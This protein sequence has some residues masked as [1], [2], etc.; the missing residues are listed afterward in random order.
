MHRFKLHRKRTSSGM[1]EAFPLD[2]GVREPVL[3][4]WV[5]PDLEP[6]LNGTCAEEAMGWELGDH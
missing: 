1:G 6:R 5:Q 4:P 3:S 2:P